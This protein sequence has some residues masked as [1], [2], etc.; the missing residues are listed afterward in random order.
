MATSFVPNGNGVWRSHELAPVGAAYF[1][2][3]DQAK[4][5]CPPLDRRHQA[6]SPG[7]ATYKRRM[8][9]QDCWEIASGDGGTSHLPD[10]ARNVQRRIHTKTEA[11][12]AAR[13]EIPFSQLAATTRACGHRSASGTYRA[14][15]V[16][17]Q[18]RKSRSTS[19]IVAA[20]SNSHNVVMP[21]GSRSTPERNLR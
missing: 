13:P 16:P 15:L 7:G 12:S 8:K 5:R 10:S 18:A 1:S 21:V 11:S 19:S 4:A 6:E 9:R 3:G 17:I 2:Q 20:P 14:S